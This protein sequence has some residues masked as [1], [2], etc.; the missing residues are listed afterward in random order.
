MWYLCVIRTA[1]LTIRL[2]TSGLFHEILSSMEGKTSGT[3][4]WSRNKNTRIQL[5]AFIQNTAP[6]NKT[7]SVSTL[8]VQKTE[9]KTSKHEHMIM[10]ECQFVRMRLKHRAVYKAKCPVS[11]PHWHVNESLKSQ[12]LVSGGSEVVVLFFLWRRLSWGK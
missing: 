6:Y 11:S 10:Q 7:W 2:N 12:C 8:K 5:K 1:Q 9:Q 4:E 3:D